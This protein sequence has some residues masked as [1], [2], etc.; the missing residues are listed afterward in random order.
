MEFSYERYG[1]VGLGTP[2]PTTIASIIDESIVKFTP[3]NANV[4]T[5]GP[6]KGICEITLTSKSNIYVS[7]D[8]DLEK[9]RKS[10]IIRIFIYFYKLSKFSAV[11]VF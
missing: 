8:F 3:C 7:T 5:E 6:D 10:K 9:F 1:T 2:D 11:M 4:I